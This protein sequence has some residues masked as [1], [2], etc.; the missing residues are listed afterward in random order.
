E[1]RDYVALLIVGK[2]FLIGRHA[3]AAFVDLL[4][5]VGLGGLFA[6]G[7][8]LILEQALEA[9]SHFLF[10]AIR[11]VADSALLED[12]FSFFRVALF[13]IGACRKRKRECGAYPEH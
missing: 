6:V 9:G 5:D 13:L 12:F 4:A 7:H 3:V 10:R 1:K 8:F 2:H 11:V